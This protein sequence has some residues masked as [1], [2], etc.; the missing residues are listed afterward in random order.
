LAISLAMLLHLILIIL[1][2]PS[3]KNLNYSLWFSNLIFVPIL[4]LLFSGKTKQRYFSPIFLF[5]MP[6]FYVIVS[7]FVIM[8]FFNNIGRWPDYLSSNFKSGNNQTVMIS[9]S[10]KSATSLPYDLNLLCEPHYGFLVFNYDK[11]YLSELHVSCFPSNFVFKGIYE[12][13]RKVS[14]TDVK[15]IELQ[16]KPKQKLLLKP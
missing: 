7:L 10:E 9:L 13:L 8:P 5:Q 4:L 16:A 1:T 2:F 14:T 3:S 11:W 12:H 15:E 6:L